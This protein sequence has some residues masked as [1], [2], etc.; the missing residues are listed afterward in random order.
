[1]LDAVDYFS[2][3]FPCSEG[4]V[5][6][7]DGDTHYNGQNNGRN[8]KLQEGEASFSAVFRGGGRTFHTGFLELRGDAFGIGTVFV[9]GDLFE[10]CAA[11]F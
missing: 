11:F 6:S 7:L 10:R 2:A 1:M 4:L 8:E 5:E 9:G 3:P